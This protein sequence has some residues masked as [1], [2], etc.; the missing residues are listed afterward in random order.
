M[1]P[2]APR[3]LFR[4]CQ[5]EFSFPLGPADGRYLAR[6]GDD[7][8]DVIVFKTPDAP[9]RS[10]VRGR[11]PKRAEPGA[12]DPDPVSISRVTV[13]DSIGFD[14]EAAASQW[15]DRCRKDE[16]EREQSVAHALGVVNRAIHAHRISAGDP[17]E[18]ELTRAH[19]QTVRLGY[20]GGDDV[21]EG[22]WRAALTLPDPRLRGRRR[23]L[24]PQEQLAAILSGRSPA[25][26]SED[27]A[28]RARLDLEQGRTRQAAIQLRAAADALEAELA[29]AEDPQNEPLG[30]LTGRKPQLH[31]LA[32][33]AA[34]G[35]ARRRADRYP[36]RI[37]RRDRA[38]RSGAA[39]TR[40]ASSP[41]VELHGEEGGDVNVYLSVCAIY[42]DEARYL[43]EWIEF[44]RLVGVERFFLYDHFSVDNHREILAPYVEQGIATV[45]EWHIDRGQVLAYNDCLERHRHD[46]RW[47]AFLDLDEFLFSPTGRPVSEVL[48]DY[49]SAPGVVV[50][51]AMFG[52]SGHVT[53]PDGLVIEN[54]L[55][56]RGDILENC[57]FKSIV[58]PKQA[59]SANGAHRFTYAHGA[60]VDENLR[61]IGDEPKGATPSLSYSR[62][63]INH[64]FQK[65][66]EG[67]R[68]K[69]AGPRADKGAPRP[70]LTEEQFSRS[71]R[72]FNQERDPDDH[73]VSREVAGGTG[74]SCEP[75]GVGV[76]YGTSFSPGSGTS[77]ATHSE[78]TNRGSPQLDHEDRVLQRVGRERSVIE[79]ADE[80]LDRFSNEAAIVEGDSPL[81]PDDAAAEPGISKRG[82]VGVL[83]VDEAHLSD[84]FEARHWKF[85]RTR[86][87]G[88]ELVEVRPGN[89]AQ[90]GEHA[91]GAVAGIGEVH[92]A[93]VWL[94]GRA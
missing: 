82:F 13:V 17:Y 76:I 38:S 14:D 68:R 4:F 71:F 75:P 10:V 62:L 59:L 21:V 61:P 49:E 52:T 88:V 44:H 24:F 9:R 39:A 48:V 73:D 50:N 12:V 23:M 65:S 92:A 60:A 66:E 34:N 70:A 69:R 11:R 40:G 5:L 2:A 45:C 90:I 86:L 16:R 56:R 41:R 22:H 93:C 74:E 18:R 46:S 43:P 63:R 58:D 51:W 20:G 83:S 15:L 25:N 47:V 91:L 30:K 3:Q 79:L 78:R 36:D 54:Y 67:F 81:R 27:L 53:E 85:I 72:D 6:S 29:A 89:C 32:A 31:E 26:P 64:Y 33:A 57:M 55:M 42:R 8:L 7:E 37:A 1:L 87:D 19:A 94:A 77:G 80:L 35:R 28:L 84:P